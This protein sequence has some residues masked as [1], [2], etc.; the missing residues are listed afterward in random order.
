MNRRQ[1]WTIIIAVSVIVLML[2]IPPWNATRSV[3]SS[4]V[5]GVIGMTEQS[6]VSLGYYA[7][8]D[9]P[10]NRLMLK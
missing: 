10:S 3:K 4:G 7:I 6:G 5:L 8:F 9:P 2:V 1:K